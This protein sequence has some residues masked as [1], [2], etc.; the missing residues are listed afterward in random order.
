MELANVRHGGLVAAQAAAREQAADHLQ[1]GE[2]LDRLL[3]IHGSALS[4]PNDHIMRWDIE[5][6][7]N[8]D[9]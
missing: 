3:E 4:P 8:S 2:W 6:L 5:Y 1:P 9:T 7:A